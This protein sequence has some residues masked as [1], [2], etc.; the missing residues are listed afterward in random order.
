[1]LRL[2]ALLL[3]LAPA[4]ALAREYTSDVTVADA[5]ELRQLFYDGLI[6]EEELAILLTLLE[7]PIDF[8][9]A[10]VQDL[11]QLPGITAA[12]AAAIVDERVLDGPYLMFA[13]IV[14][15]VPDF[16]AAS[17]ALVEPFAFVRP[18]GGKGPPVKG[19]VEYLAFKRFRSVAPIANDYPGRS[20]SPGQLGYNNWPAMALT[21]GMDVLGVL[22]LGLG[23]IVQEGLKSAEYDPASRDLYVSWGAPL[24]RPY[25]AYARLKRDKGELIGGYYH[26]HYGHGLVMSTISGRDRHGFFVRQSALRGEDRISQWNGLV[27]VAA[28]A[29]AIPLGRADLDVSVFTNARPYDVFSNYMAYG[30]ADGGPVDTARHL[31]D[32]D[33]APYEAERPRLW[34]D[35]QR[36]SGQSLPNAMG[37]VLGGGNATVRFNRRTFIGLTGYGAW[38][39]RTGIKGIDDPYTLVYTQR[40]PRREAFGAMGVHGAIGFG[41]VD[42]SGEAAFWFEQGEPKTALFFVAE[43]EPWW[44]ELVASIRHYDR[45]YANPFTR[46]VAAPDTVAGIRARD[47]DGVRVQ[48]TVNPLKDK[49]RFQFRGDLSRNIAFDIH[50]LELSTSVRG[51]L[52]DWLRLVFRFE[53]KNQNLAVNGTEHRYSADLDFDDLAAYLYTQQDLFD[54]LETEDLTERTYLNRA[55][56]R[57]AWTTSA[58]LQHK[59]L[60]ALELRYQQRFVDNR[61]RHLRAGE[62]RFDMQGGHRVRLSGYVRPTKT[63]T[64]RGAFSWYDD[65]WSGSR[66]LGSEDGV[67]SVFGY[68]QAEQSIKQNL[69]IR[70]RGGVGR[71]LPNVPSGCDQA[72]ELDGTFLPAGS[73][74][75]EPDDYDLR[76]FGEF[77]VSVRVKF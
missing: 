62:C 25:L 75:Y 30:D 42:L 63:T 17:V 68:V 21:G 8:N 20:H 7:S 57:I 38:M 9:R 33:A 11:Y 43:I 52:V 4:S 6:E 34:V 22:D 66:S 40:W 31:I 64:I 29:P 44:G 51:D 58:R 56:Q 48:L 59:K 67:T 23:L 65:D 13:D 24:F 12:V 32:P 45:D 39:N 5:N 28:R 14:E 50:N 37:V 16:T 3:L 26:A 69:K 49:F 71:R 73:V 74:E 77:L 53:Y 60:G 70:L 15:R 27:G 1:V 2:F 61:K 54:L 47:E 36:I 41:L 19:T 72:E 76:H 35:G 55:G 46:A 10:G 18:A